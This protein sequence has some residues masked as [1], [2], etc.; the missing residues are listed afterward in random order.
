MKKLMI[1]ACV[2]A[3]AGLV[4]AQTAPQRD[5]VAAAH[6]ASFTEISQTATALGTMVGQPMT[7]AML[8]AAAQQ[9][10]AKD[11]GQLDAGLPL[12]A[13]VYLDTKG[14][15][16]L[17]I[18]KDAAKIAELGHW[19]LLYPAAGGES[20]FLAGRVGATKGADGVISLGGKKKKLR[21]AKF[22]ADGRYCA[23]AKTADQA[24]RAV[25]D[26]PAAAAWL[27]SKK[28][29][30]VRVGVNAK[31][32]DALAWFSGQVSAAQTKSLRETLA[33]GEA[34]EALVK[35][36]IALQ[37]R[38]REQ[39]VA[40]LRSCG[41]I[42]VATGF[43]DRGFAVWDGVDLRPGAS[44]QL[45][46]AGAALPGKA[47]DC[48]PAGVG[49][50]CALNLF[51]Q[52]P[53]G[54][55][56][57]LV[58]SCID[59]LEG[60]RAQAAKSKD[61]DFAKYR[62][63][64]DDV[65][66]A[67]VDALRPSV[68]A[69]AGKG[70]WSSLSLAFDARKRPLLASVSSCTQTPAQIAASDRLLG[71]IIQV[72]ERQWPGSGFM[73]KVA[74]GS[75][76]I[77]WANIVDFAAKST[78][79]TN[80]SDVAEIAKIKK[81]FENVLGGTTS[82]LKFKSGAAGGCARFS[83]PGV[84]VAKAPAGEGASRLFAVLPEAKKDAMLSYIYFTPYAFARDVVMP[85]AVKFADKDEA[86]QIQAVAAALPPAAPGG[87]LAYGS[88]LRPDGNVRFAFRISADE[89]KTIGSAVTALTAAGGD[90]DDE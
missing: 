28:P 7:P 54:D 48:I 68:G 23:F 11:Y 62:Q 80:A 88:W 70:D 25:A 72:C 12:Y 87:A 65:L 79:A 73:K 69:K 75:Y 74:D 29:A 38:Q 10:L 56:G 6:V 89:I 1:I 31:G 90:D 71:R 47:F 85:V 53:D 30:L 59:I 52:C 19:A 51:S 55:I 40:Q 24:A 14:L 16:G 42:M 27:K 39:S 78:A 57:S 50:S 81:G 61:E 9:T 77:D 82:E 33:G 32:I 13:L 21:F 5:L 63:S 44:A 45:V 17:D 58:Q 36:L 46:P 20:A 67:F 3:A 49:L 83:A 76:L 66:A 60:A 34:D 43:D 8:L 15:S 84:A 2:A 37:A 35:G 86:Q 64:V 18:E 26:L 4:T 22:T 41:Q